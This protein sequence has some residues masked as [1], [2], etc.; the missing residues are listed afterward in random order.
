MKGL[1]VSIIALVAALAV[2]AQAQEIELDEIVV[3]ANQTATEKA[4][5]GASVS[6]VSAAQISGAQG[7][8][9]TS[10]LEKLPGVTL[11][12]L[13]PIGT[14]AGITI[15]GCPIPTSSCELTASM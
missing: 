7:V 4:K 3:T 5:V 8:R 2:P 6:T 1:N 9:A 15:R 10:A 12:T 14:Q 13:G 11:R